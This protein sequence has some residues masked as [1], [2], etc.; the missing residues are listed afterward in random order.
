MLIYNDQTGEKRLITPIEDT[1]EPTSM[2]LLRAP[3]Q[4]LLVKLPRIPFNFTLGDLPV[5]IPA[6]GVSSSARKK[7]ISQAQKDKLAKNAERSRRRYHGMT[8]E[9]KRE[10]NKRRSEQAKAK[11][12]K[13]KEILDK[14]YEEAT[15]E[16]LE[17]AK[18]VV[19]GKRIRTNVSYFVIVNSIYI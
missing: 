8:A 5:E 13:L 18:R 9:Q 19:T 16:D 4:F 3:Q 12:A 1:S 7:T 14:P 6:G 2:G 11:R 17:F 15:E 10:Y